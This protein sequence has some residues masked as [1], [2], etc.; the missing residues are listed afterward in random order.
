VISVKEFRIIE[1][2]GKGVLKE[3]LA[4]KKEDKQ[5]VENREQ[6]KLHAGE[7]AKRNAGK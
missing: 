1:D 2:I 3:D 7:S 5:H 4:K 6:T